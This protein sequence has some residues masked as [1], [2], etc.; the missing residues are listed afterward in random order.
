MAKEFHLYFGDYEAAKSEHCLH[1]YVTTEAAIKEGKEIIHTT[2]VA[3][4]GMHL[5]TQHGYRIF[6]YPEIGKPFEV[7]LGDCANTN[8]LIREGHNLERLLIAGEFN[9]DTTTVCI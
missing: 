9:T 8:R 4:I 6:I 5:I 3:C 2:Q 7:T 1:T